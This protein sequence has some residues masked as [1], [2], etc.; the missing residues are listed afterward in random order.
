MILR[1]AK[2]GSSGT[3]IDKVLINGAEQKEAFLPA[4][5]KGNQKISIVMKNG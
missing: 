4:G 2:V 5:I 3:V 1:S